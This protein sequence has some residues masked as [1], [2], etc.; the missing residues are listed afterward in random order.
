M[1][2]LDNNFFFSSV[3]IN[4]LAILLVLCHCA[5]AQYYLRGE[6]QDE[7]GK[8][9]ESA[10][11]RIQSKGTYLF[12]SGANG[13]FGIPVSMAKDSITVSYDGYEILKKEI[14]CRVFQ[15]IVLKI[16]PSTATVMQKRLASR[17][18]NLSTEDNNNFFT[19]L[20]E[21]Y[22]SYIENKFVET[23]TYPETGFSLNI[24]R[25]S[26]SNMRR[27]INNQLI[28]PADAVRIEEMLN[29]FDLKNPDLQNNYREFIC[30]TFMS[31]CPWNAKTKLFNINITAPRL[32]LDSVAPASF[33]FL[34]D[35]SG[36]MDR[37]NR[38]PL[39]QSAFKL[40]VENLRTKDTVSIVTYGGGVHIA[41]APTDGSNKNKII[42]VIDS[43]Y[44]DGDTPGEN[45]I[46]TAY[47]IARHSFIKNGNNRVILATDGDFNV[48][49]TSDKDLEDLIAF[50]KQSGIYL[51]CL[52][53]GMGNYKDSKLEALA[54]KGNGNFAYLD[55]IDEAEKVLV[56]EFT[57]TMYSV[58]NDA[59]LNVKFNNEVVK[60]YRLIGFDNKKG[61]LNDSTSSISGGEIGSGH[62]TTAIFEIELQEEITNDTAAIALL[63]LNYK[64]PESKQ[65]VVKE[66]P[67]IIRQSQLN[68]VPNRIL[69][70]NAI[71]MAGQIFKQSAFTKNYT[72]NDV[73]KIA[74]KTADP[75][76]AQ[77]S[78]F[79]LILQKAEKIYSNRNNKK[80]RK[81]D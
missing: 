20:G 48:G 31:N 77:Q 71:A 50:Q 13:L 17:T 65:V 4:L 24:D 61:A 78:E 49:Q 69:F 15:T 33:T 8:P 11:I 60:K 75:F 70:A 55:N 22:S 81:S 68:K 46:R 56:K 41:L 16:L 37:P 74:E 26:Y 62:N 40:L 1:A 36:S 12:F 80:K 38:L 45:A 3:K 43:L 72:F 47:D 51:T 28:V 19:A 7:K 76:N 23:G 21:S 58:A 53:V 63:K 10:K 29:Y 73:L 59:Y 79:L 52:G 14:D 18:T 34:I 54:K 35:V 5:G 25:A 30:E 42:G 67:S 27:F 64:K 66:W 44:A 9:L 6:V 32:N 57:K 2:Y 39:L